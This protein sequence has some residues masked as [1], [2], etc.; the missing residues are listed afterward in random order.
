MQPT[1]SKRFRIQD[2]WADSQLHY[3]LECF[4]SC[5]VK[6]SELCKKHAVHGVI[7]IYLHFSQIGIMFCH[8]AETLI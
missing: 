5:G 8:V 3:L 7:K 1:V 4:R 6:S 2:W